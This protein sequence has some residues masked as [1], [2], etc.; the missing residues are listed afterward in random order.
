MQ[1][2]TSTILGKRKSQSCFEDNTTPMQ[3]MVQYVLGSGLIGLKIRVRW[4][5]MF[6]SLLKIMPHWLTIANMINLIESHFM[7]RNITYTFIVF[8]QSL[9]QLYFDHHSE[10]FWLLPTSKS[11]SKSSSICWLTSSFIML[12]FY[13]IFSHVFF[14]YYI[15]QSS[16]LFVNSIKM[17]KL[18][19]HLYWIKP[20]QMQNFNWQQKWND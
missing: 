14:L 9:C 1:A 5:Q 4:K 2:I 8:H 10:T 7:S 17:S 11:M 18:T 12:F 3:K 15:L 6:H 13:V 16:N 19:Q 20:N